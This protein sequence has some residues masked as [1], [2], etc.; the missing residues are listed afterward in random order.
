[1]RPCLK[2][3]RAVLRGRG[4]AQLVECLP[5]IHEA[6]P[7]IKLDPAVL[8]YNLALRKQRQENQKAN[9]VTDGS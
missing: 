3:N 7:H 1:M 2:V 9:K 4:V 8:T 5:S 6:L